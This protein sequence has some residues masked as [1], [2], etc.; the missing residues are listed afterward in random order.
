MTTTTTYLFWAAPWPFLSLSLDVVTHAR[1]QITR[2]QARGVRGLLAPFTCFYFYWSSSFFYI[3]FWNYLYTHLRALPQARHHLGSHSICVCRVV[4]PLEAS[5]LTLKN[6]VMV[7]LPPAFFLLY[8]LPAS[9]FLIILF[10][11]HDL[12]RRICLTLFHQ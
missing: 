9:L 4:L 6:Q 8:C 12:R 7:P 11:T 1:I 10:S 2:T 3:Y 5:S